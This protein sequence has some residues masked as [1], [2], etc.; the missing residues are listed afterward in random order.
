[1]NARSSGWLKR[2][3]LIWA[4]V[5][6]VAAL[7]F[8]SLALILFVRLLSAPELAPAV[9]TQTDSSPQTAA[10]VPRPVW[11]PSPE[12]LALAYPTFGQRSTR[13]LNS[14]FNHLTDDE[15]AG[16]YRFFHESSAGGIITLQ[17]D[18]SMINKEGITV[19]Q[20]RWAIQSDGILT[21]WRT[22]TVLFNDID[23]PGVYVARRNDGV[24]YGRIEKVTE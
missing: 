4:I 22:T 16:R 20:Y 15:V 14:S 2:F 3:L 13:P 19:R 9:A 8:A 10:R 5:A 18:H 11:A 12:E 21:K 1:M 6:S 24:E 17:P 7:A 23:K